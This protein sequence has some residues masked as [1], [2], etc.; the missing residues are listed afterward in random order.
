MLD[1][2]TTALNPARRMSAQGHRFNQATHLDMQ[3]AEP[4]QFF[5]QSLSRLHAHRLCDQSLS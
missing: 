1:K 3:P 5:N 2:L 4:T